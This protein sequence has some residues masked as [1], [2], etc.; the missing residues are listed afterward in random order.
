MF[1]LLVG[2]TEF[3]FEAATAAAATAPIS[4]LFEIL[5]EKPATRVYVDNGEAK[6]EYINDKVPLR[7]VFP[8]F[9]LPF[10]GEVDDKTDA[11]SESP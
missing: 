11:C 6:C 1:V 3:I 9:V 5:G 10:F 7:I 8:F 2:D 4:Y